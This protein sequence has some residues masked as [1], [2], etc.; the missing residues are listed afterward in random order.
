MTQSKASAWFGM[1]NNKWGWRVEYYDAQGNLLT[2]DFYQD[3]YKVGQARTEALK[4]LE[5]VR[6]LIAA[7][8]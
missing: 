7:S 2:K 1:W 5:S 4:F 3:N 8:A 6:N